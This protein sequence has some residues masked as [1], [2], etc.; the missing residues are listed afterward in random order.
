MSRWL[1]LYESVIVRTLIVLSFVM[2]GA[3]GLG[4]AATTGFIGLLLLPIIAIAAIRAGLSEPA[5]ILFL[6]AA[7]A[8]AGISLSWSPYDR[9]DQ[10]LKLSLLSPLFVL[11]PFALSRFSESRKDSLFRWLSAC[12]VILALFFL[13]EAASNS[14][15][16]R[17]LKL[18]IDG[19]AASEQAQILA[20][21]VLGRGVSA[22]LMVLGPAAF[23]LWALGG[24]VRRAAALLL[25]LAGAL[26]SVSFGIEANFL[27]LCAATVAALLAW[28]FPY[29]TLQIGLV[30]G[31]G[32]IIAAPLLMGAVISLLPPAMLD[33]LPLS[34]AMRIE[35]WRFAMENIAL[36]PVFGHGLD[37]SRVISDVAVLRGESFDR[38]PL[39]AHNAGLTIWLET[40]AVGALLFGGVLVALSQ[41]IGRIRISRVQAAS[42]AFTAV[43]FFTTVLV[44]SGV[45]QEWLHGALAFAIGAALLI[46]R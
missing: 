44:G 42:I 20:D 35:I 13:F 34:W 36:A 4:M 8:W 28:R 38:L 27:A 19:A 6:A 29:S 16:T 33:A 10:A 11:A 23:G 32:M 21:R 15:I 2:I 18:H 46:R 45:W 37:A 40:G 39:H 22:Y 41:A 9:P 1:R 5:P 24:G 25:F 26:G 17:M 3:G 30:T 31:A 12:A 14:L 7:V 43:V